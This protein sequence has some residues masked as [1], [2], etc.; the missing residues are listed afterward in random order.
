MSSFHKF[1]WKQQNQIRAQNVKIQFSVQHI[2]PS[3]W[4]LKI[5]HKEFLALKLLD[6]E[7]AAANHDR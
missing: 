3:F 2:H 1:A 5:S 4:S 6:R 7:D